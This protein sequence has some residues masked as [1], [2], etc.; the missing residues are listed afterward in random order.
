M[1]H[2]CVW[3]TE[4]EQMFLLL[5]SGWSL[6]SLYMRLS[7]D[8]A[9]PRHDW[10]SMNS[11]CTLL[12]RQPFSHY[13]QHWRKQHLN[14]TKPGHLTQFRNP[15][16]KQTWDVLITKWRVRLLI[17]AFLLLFFSEFWVCCHLL[18]LKTKHFFRTLLSNSGRHMISN[19]NQINFSQILHFFC[20]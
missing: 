15:V 16:W 17:A 9:F 10:S 2:T 4:R 5:F 11:A 1:L 3:I 12:V 20:V 19:L 8:P 6:I 18:E 13:L 7:V 14:N